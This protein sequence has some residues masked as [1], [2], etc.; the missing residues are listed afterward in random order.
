MF[1]F[2]IKDMQSLS[3]QQRCFNGLIVDFE[4]VFTLRFMFTGAQPG[5]F[6]GRVGFL[7]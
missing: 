5:I 7:E 4:L 6:Q 2:N 3:E 1:K